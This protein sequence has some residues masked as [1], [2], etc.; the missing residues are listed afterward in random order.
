MSFVAWQISKSSVNVD[1][2]PSNA[3][4]QLVQPESSSEIIERSQS[5][6][7][8]LSIPAAALTDNLMTTDEKRSKRRP[9]ACDNGKSDK[10]I[11]SQQQS[12]IQCCDMSGEPVDVDASSNK[13]LH[14]SQHT[15]SNSCQSHNENLSASQIAEIYAYEHA[16]DSSNEETDVIGWQRKNTHLEFDISNWRNCPAELVGNVPYDIDGRCKYQLLCSREEM[17]QCAKDGRPW[18]QYM[19]SSRKSFNGVRRVTRCRGSFTCDADDCP[20]L[21]QGVGPNRTQF[22]NKATYPECFSCGAQ[23]TRVPCQAIKIVEY[24]PK[25]STL[26]IM[27]DVRHTCKAKKPRVDRSVLLKAVANN[28]GVKPNKLVNDHMVQL[29]SSDSFEWSEIENV[30]SAFADLKRVH[31]ARAELA[32]QLNPVG[33]S[34]EALGVF[35]EKCDERD[36]YLVYKINCRQLNGRPA[37]V[38]KSSRAMAQSA[39]AMERNKN[40]CLSREYAHVDAMHDRVRG[41]KTLTLWTYSET[42][43]KLICLAIMEVGEENVENLTSFWNVLNEMLQDFT[44]QSDYKFNPSGF[45]ADEHHANWQSISKVFGP[46]AID[47]TVSCEFHFKQSVHRHARRLPESSTDFIRIANALLEASSENEFELAC[48]EM[49]QLLLKNETLYTWFNWWLERKTHIFRAF[50]STHAPSTNL[51]EVGH[52]KLAS[53]GRR[54][55][56]LLEAARNDVAM[57]IRQGVEL[58]GFVD[59]MSSGGRGQT[60]IKRNAKT[61]R[62]ELKRAAAYGNEISMT[63]VPQKRGTQFIQSDGIHRPPEGVAQK[64]RR[65][66]VRQLQLRKAINVRRKQLAHKDVNMTDGKLKFEVL[67]LVKLP[68]VKVCYG[69][70]SKFATKYYTAP[71]DLILR[72]FCN[73]LYR[74]NSGAVKRSNKVTAAYCHLKMT[75]VNKVQPG[76]QVRNDG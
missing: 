1:N 8:L 28:P 62:A 26:T 48:V 66:N 20:F 55:M 21:L 13:S 39:V 15:I 64:P 73:R 71:N 52:S 7:A 34:C 41:F 67:Q 16:V 11:Q 76:T 29:M 75:C 14:S 47:R 36:C 50:K 22:R 30:A 68:R 19:T 17:M 35:K 12:N 70:T 59:G 37:F 63:S 74:D 31:N 33:Q 54:G 40:G 42:Q 32:S 56:S 4:A 44:G 60:S 2:G 46:S 38:F 23:A 27:H 57:A 3:T 43:C 24:E 65:V 61:H 5:F 51:A 72:T 6:N 69:C 9:M 49:E 18:K 58:Q 53:V 45:V 25:E 10:G